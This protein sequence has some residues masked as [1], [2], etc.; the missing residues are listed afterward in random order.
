MV[1]LARMTLKDPRVVLLDEPTTG[2]DQTSEVYALRAL[3]HWCQSRT[4]VVVT[5]RSQVLQL[6]NRIVVVE[7]GKVVLD[8]PRD[9]VL[10]HLSAKEKQP[11]TQETQKIQETQE[12]Q[13]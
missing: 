7:D 6:V 3:A 10:K 11:A 12:T 1:A 8:G 13:E 9:A 4:L 5:H 2:L